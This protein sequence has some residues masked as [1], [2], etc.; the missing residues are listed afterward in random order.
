[1]YYIKVLNLTLKPVPIKY[2]G[3]LWWRPLI[4]VAGSVGDIKMLYNSTKL[5]ANRKKYNFK[6]LI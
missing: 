4:G 2:V 6:I 3:D 5:L 1:M